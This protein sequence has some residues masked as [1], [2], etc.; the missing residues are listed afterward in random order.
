M[1]EQRGAGE[2]VAWRVVRSSTP[3][4]STPTRSVR[5]VSSSSKRHRVSARYDAF[6]SWYDEWIA[7]PEDDLV[8]R[9]L[10]DLV[11]PRR[12]ERILDLGCGQGRIARLLAEAGNHVVGVDLSSELLAI[13]RAKG[14]RQVR[15]IH[16][17]VCAS[18]WWDGTPFDGVIASMS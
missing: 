9:S 16:A 2:D 3:A 10:L 6:S 11:G 15:Y 4:S 12:D 8:A 18:D 1:V 7:A 5:S 14:G 17:D 13:A